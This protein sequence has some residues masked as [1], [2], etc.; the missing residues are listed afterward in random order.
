MFFLFSVLS[1]ENKKMLKPCA[2]CVFAVIK[3][4]FHKKNRMAILSR[5]KSSLADRFLCSKTEVDYIFF[6]GGSHFVCW[7]QLNTLRC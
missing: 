7:P 4:F 1:K 3:Y 6:I 2:L 5:L